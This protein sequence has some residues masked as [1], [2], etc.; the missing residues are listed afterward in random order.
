MQYELV[1]NSSLKFVPLLS[2]LILTCGQVSLS[3]AAHIDVKPY[4]IYFSFYVV[5]NNVTREVSWYLDTW[6]QGM[7][8][9][10][11]KLHSFRIANKKLQINKSTSK[12]MNSKWACKQRKF[13]PHC[14]MLVGGRAKS[15]CHD[16][17][18]NCLGYR[19]LYYVP[20]PLPSSILACN[21]SSSA[22]WS[23]T[24]PPELLGVGVTGTQC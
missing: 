1:S 24:T 5:W 23:P 19:V 10:G 6:R 9:H 16:V 3:F 22:Y 15:W 4:F 20:G 17:K 7:E 11:R 13:R 8:T 2:I 18:L 21:I 14:L 12:N